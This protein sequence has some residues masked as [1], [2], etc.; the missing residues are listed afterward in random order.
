M[1][2]ETSK[3]S[4]GQVLVDALRIHGVERV[5]G[6]PGE[7]YLAALDALHDVEDAIEFIVCRQGRRRR[8][9]GGSLRQ[10]DRQTR[11]LLR[12]PRAGRD[13][14]VRRRAYRFPGI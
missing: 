8:L 10:D 5:F 2:N 6:V 4:G 14:R 11:H 7:S 12:D 3:R 13:E 1:K 9:Y